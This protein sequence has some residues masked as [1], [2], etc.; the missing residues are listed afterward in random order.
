[1]ADGSCIHIPFSR[2]EGLLVG[3][4]SGSAMAGTLKYLRE[5]EDGRSVAADPA[6]NVVVIFADGIRNYMGK[7]RRKPSWIVESVVRNSQLTRRG[8]AE[9]VSARDSSGAMHRAGELDNRMSGKRRRRRKRTRAAVEITRS[10]AS[11]YRRVKADCK[12]Q[13]YTTCPKCTKSNNSVPA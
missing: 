8:L 10:I 13:R 3:G 7:V 1:M 6:A 5:T 11:A 2:T 12:H 4:S 9:L